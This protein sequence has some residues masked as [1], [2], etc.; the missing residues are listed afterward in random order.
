VEDFQ[1]RLQR[2]SGY[3]PIDVYD[4]KGFDDYREVSDHVS[5]QKV[6]KQITLIDPYE[7]IGAFESDLIYKNQLNGI[8]GQLNHLG[9]RPGGAA[10]MTM[11]NSSTNDTSGG[12]GGS[13]GTAMDSL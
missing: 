10:R 3:K 9:Q 6:V 2:E 13:R 11:S 12:N 5:I 7:T 4:W 8:M 1:H